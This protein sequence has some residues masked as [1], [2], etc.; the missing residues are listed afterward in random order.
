MTNGSYMVL[1]ANNVNSLAEQV[2]SHMSSGWVPLGGVA[3]DGGGFKYQAMVRASVEQSGL[4]DDSP[5]R[6]V[7]KKG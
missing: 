2:S 4:S 5:G 1:V 3:V 6:V 7:A